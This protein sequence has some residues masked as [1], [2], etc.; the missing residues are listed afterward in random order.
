MFTTA[1]A[2]YA[3]LQER[4]L[5]MQY[6]NRRTVVAGVLL[7]SVGLASPGTH[8]AL[9]GELDALWSAL[10]SGQAIAV[11]RHALAPGTGDPASFAIGDCSTQRNLSDVGR[12][13]AKRVG[14][15]FRERGMPRA[16]VFSSAWCRCLETA[17]LLDLGEVKPLPALNSFYTAREREDQQTAAL[18]T[19]LASRARDT[20]VVLI[21]HQVNITALTG[22]F[23]TSGEIVVVRPEAGGEVMVL[24]TIRPQD[25]ANTSRCDCGEDDP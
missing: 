17:E 1:F 7:A 9:A 23:P 13:Q 20:A 5:V 24:G 6:P 4:K 8:A 12:A 11:M 15:M 18:K 16:A 19:W 2:R 14:E 10:R 25:D 21:T 3:Y 22:V